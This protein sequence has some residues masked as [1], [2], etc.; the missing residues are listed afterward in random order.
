MADGISWLWPR[1]I[2]LR[3]LGFFGLLAFYDWICSVDGLI[4]PFGIFPTEKYLG[5]TAPG[6]DFFVKL[7]AEPTLFWLSTEPW[8]L[9]LVVWGGLL[10]SAALLLNLA[11]RAAITVVWLC[12]L[13]LMAP[14]TPVTSST[15]LDLL[16]VELFF[17]AIFVA[18]GGLRP[19]LAADSPPLRLSIFLLRMTVL[20]VMLLNGLSK[21]TSGD[22]KW[23]NFT[24]M[25]HMYETA[26]FPTVL[27]Y[28]AHQ[29]P[30]AY[31]AFECLLMVMA[32]IVAPLLLLFGGRRAKIS[33]LAIWITFQLGI[34][35]TCNFGSLNLVAIIAAVVLVDDDFLAS[36]FVRLRLATPLTQ[37][38]PA[39]LKRW[40]VRLVA[41]LS[42]TSSAAFTYQVL[43]SPQS[44][45]PVII[46]ALQH[47]LG[48]LRV[49]NRIAIYAS[50][51]EQ[52]VHP[53]IE[54]SNDNGKTWHEYRFRHLIQ[55]LDLMAPYRAPILPRFDAMMYS[56]EVDFGGQGRMVWPLIAQKIM[57]A[58]P[59]IVSLFRENPFPDRPPDTLRLGLYSYRFVDLS[60]HR[61]TGNFWNRKYLG[62]GAAQLTMDRSTGQVSGAENTFPAP[63]R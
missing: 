16:L 44:Q 59:E 57:W 36:L 49:G 8:M 23:W 22:I 43:I 17:L 18:P 25:D 6:A 11:P 48:G 53:I 19:R 50:L 60:T 26:P 9:H 41:V 29:L 13:S 62:E 40:T 42:L 63:G 38:S 15:Q 7:L 14:P 55:E 58:R 39:F 61:K 12:V 21:F 10:S 20:K 4:G 27:G 54:G 2:L 52:R 32:E 51:P 28:Y 5:M 24:A 31:H 47:W 3:A 1:W 30:H 46:G 45:P 35:L 37:A 34:E 33:A 56:L